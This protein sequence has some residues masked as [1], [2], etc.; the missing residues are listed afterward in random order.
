MSH[1]HPPSRQHPATCEVGGVLSHGL[2]LRSFPSRKGCGADVPP[3][4]FEDNHGFKSQGNRTTSTSC[5]DPSKPPRQF[6]HPFHAKTCA[7]KGPYFCVEF[8]GRRTS[9]LDCPCNPFITPAHAA[10]YCVR[11]LTWVV[12]KIRVLWYPYI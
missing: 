4:E 1:V 6:Q 10:P 8:H 3:A 9:S 12:P 2:L 5:K 11:S 7:K